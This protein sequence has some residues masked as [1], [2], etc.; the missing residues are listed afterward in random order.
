MAY[1]KAH[2][3]YEFWKATLNH[4]ESS[5]KKWVHYYEARCVGIDYHHILMN[6]E[7]VSV[8]SKNR[9]KKFFTLTPVEQLRTYGY[10]DMKT[11]SFLPGCYYFKNDNNYV[12][13]GIIGSS[14]MLSKGKKKTLVLFIGYNKGNYCELTINNPIG[15]NGKVIG[16]KSTSKNIDEIQQCYEAYKYE[17]F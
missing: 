8:Y 16:V 9:M 17:F 11:D 14:R 13:K 6:K 3:P 10:W 15:F 7:D 5:Y 1:V 4:C 12:I 2:Y